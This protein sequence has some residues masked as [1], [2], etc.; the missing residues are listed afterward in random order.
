MQEPPR[1]GVGSATNNMSDMVV[2]PY[3][4]PSEPFP[5]G[6]ND[7]L[8]TSHVTG[9]SLVSLSPEPSESLVPNYTTQ[10]FNSESI[11]EHIGISFIDSTTADEQFENLLDFPLHSDKITA[12]QFE[13]QDTIEY[14]EPIK[15]I[16]ND[17][18][19]I[20][21][22]HLPEQVSVMLKTECSINGQVQATVMPANRVKNFGT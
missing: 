22:N 10:E 2:L 18:E 4:E 11:I 15:D 14:L 5:A 12:S 16:I 13:K 1:T 3:L 9:R 21:S 20:P 8:V 17:S 7:A 19:N 6:T